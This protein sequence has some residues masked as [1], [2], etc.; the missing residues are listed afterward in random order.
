MCGGQSDI[1]EK[2]RP[3]LEGSFAGKVVNCGS[4]G[5]GMAIKAINNTLNLAHNIIAC[6]G[7]LALKKYGVE[8]NIALDVI[9]ASSG[10][11][12]ATEVRVP[13]EVLT[14][15]FNYGFALS[16]MSKDCKIGAG[17]I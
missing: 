5:S 9:N 13:Q 6:E 17:L 3:I 16:L 1:I 15:N 8:P 14:G 2:L 11:S 7:L 4:V 12:F 10:R